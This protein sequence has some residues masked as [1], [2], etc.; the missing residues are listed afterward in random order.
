M[1]GIERKNV[2]RHIENGEHITVLKDVFERKFI[3]S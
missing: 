3:Q 2:Y 1:I